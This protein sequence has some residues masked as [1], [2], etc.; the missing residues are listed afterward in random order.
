MKFVISPAVIGFLG[1]LSVF[2]ATLAVLRPEESLF[3]ADSREALLAQ[4]DLKLRKAGITSIG[5][6]ALLLIGALATAM[7][8]VVSLFATGH[9]FLSIVLTCTVPPLMSFDLDRRSR[10]FS[11]K[12]VG[13]LVPLM[14]KVESQIRVGKNPTTAFSIAANDDPLIRSVLAEQLADLQL[15]AP[16]IDVLRATLDPIP[17]RPWLHFVRSMEVFMDQGGELA[18]VINAN[19]QRMSSQI[20]LR[21]RLMGDVAQYRGQQFVLLGLG[22]AIPGGMFF[23]AGDIYGSVFST[24]VG[25]IAFCVSVGIMVGGLKLTQSGIRTVERRLGIGS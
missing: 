2:F 3:N 21:K 12:L 8:F 13:R 6:G 24:P 23:V 1:G 18:D 22:V 10:S 11:E 19:V 9:L 17:V 5:P 25:I 20:L 14:R 4:L 7:T 15:N 16:F